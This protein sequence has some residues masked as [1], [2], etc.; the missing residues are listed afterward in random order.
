MHIII[1]KSLST[2][3]DTRFIWK[4]QYIILIKTI[5]RLH[6]LEETSIFQNNSTAT[7]M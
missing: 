1:N 6:Q 2:R 3:V 5:D 4:T 7:E